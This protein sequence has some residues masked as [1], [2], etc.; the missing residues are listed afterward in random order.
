MEK[1]KK[2]HSLKR[3]FTIIVM[4]SILSVFLAS[5]ITIYSCYRLQ[6]YILPDS[7][8]VWLTAKRITSDGTETEVK[9]RFALDQASALCLLQV[10]GGENPTAQEMVY[11]IEKMESGYSALTPNRKMVYQAAQISMIAL[12]L[13]YSMIGISLSGWWFYQ[14]KIAPPVQILVKATEH[15]CDN[16]LDFEVDSVSGDELGQ[17]CE[18]F[19]KMRQTLYENNRQLWGMIEE[20]RILQASV[21]HDLRNTIAI[22]ECYIEYMQ[23]KFTSGKLSGE[24]LQHT[25]SNLAAAAKRLERY[26]D[27]I[28]DLH[29]LEETELNCSAMPLCDFLNRIADDFTIMA[30]QQNKHME[31][32]FEAATCIVSLDKEVLSRILENVFANALRYAKETIRF[33]AFLQKDILTLRMMDDGKGFSEQVLGKK[34]A[35]F[36]SEDT[37]GEHMGLGLAASRVLCQKHGG[38]M[39]LSNLSPN[40]A[41]VKITVMVKAESS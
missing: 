31:Y 16:D 39:E 20:R 22:I 35:L 34:A 6:K 12:P 36:F 29:A 9:Q 41:C 25:L 8:A 26:T 3:D 7:N 2:F 24:K 28:R 4:L 40:G 37:T 30:H 14:R 5:L 23:N 13:L 21:A 33:T 1:V 27:D 38:S 17:L 32:E 11:T 19:E 15:I 18:A 10:Q